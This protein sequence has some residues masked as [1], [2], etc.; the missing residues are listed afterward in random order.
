MLF[1]SAKSKDKTIKIYD[2]AWH[3]LTTGEPEDVRA[4]VFKDMIA[5]LEKRL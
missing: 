4:K 5:W 3:V 2:G 1:D